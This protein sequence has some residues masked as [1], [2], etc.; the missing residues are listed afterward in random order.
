MIFKIH[1]NPY[2]EKKN[3][4]TK[5][6][7][8]LEP[9]NIYCFTGCNGSGKSTLI[10]E[11]TDNNLCNKANEIKPDFYAKAFGELFAKNKKLYPIKYIRFDKKVE[12][13]NSENDYFMNA[14]RV[15]FSSTGEGIMDRFGNILSVI[16]SV[17]RQL[18]KDNTLF[19]FIDDADAGT[20]LD[21]IS[22]IIDVLDLI[23]NDLEKK[24]ITYYIILTA[25]S[26]ELCRNY[27]CIDVNTFAH[28]T[29]KRYETYK[30][31]VLKSRERKNKRYE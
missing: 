25:N 22:Q 16:G 15:S 1:K 14:M 17:V 18:K 6:H 24:E 7:L 4:Y 29:F 3:I 21:N 20:S 28:K 30:K 26:F 23:K 11:I 31:Y 12:V 8:E 13:S 2:D 10:R 19:I 27:E 5:A 9:N